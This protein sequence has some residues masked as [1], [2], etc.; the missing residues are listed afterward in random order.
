MADALDQIL[1]DLNGQPSRNLEPRGDYLDQVLA[2][3]DAGYRSGIP[4]PPR[5]DAAG[6]GEPQQ[7]PQEKLPEA[8]G[9]LGATI[10]GAI[11]TAAFGFADEAAGFLETL[12][13]TAGTDATSVWSSGKSFG[14]TLSDNIAYERGLAKANAKE[15]PWAY[16]G[17]QFAGAVLVPFGAGAK[18]ALQVAKVGAVQGAVYGVGSETAP[19]AGA[20]G[21]GDDGVLTRAL[22]GG[23]VGGAAGGLIGKAVDAATPFVRKFLGREATKAAEGLGDEVTDAVGLDVTVTDDTPG[24][25]GVVTDDSP[26]LA[27]PVEVTEAKQPLAW[28]EPDANG[29]RT[30]IFAAEEAAPHPTPEIAAAHAEDVPLVTPEGAPAG[31]ISRA[32]LQDLQAQ[33]EHFRTQ[34]GKSS[35][36][37]VDITASSPEHPTLG[38]FRLG[39]LGDDAEPMSLLGAL[40]RQL[41]GLEP[42][43]DKQ[44]IAQVKA[45]AGELAGGD[46][47]ALDALA[48]QIAGPAGRPDLAIGVLRTVQRR[49]AEEMDLFHGTG[50]DWSTATDEMVQAAGQ[51]IFNVQKVNE[52]VQS[53]KVGAGRALRVFSLPNSERYFEAMAAKESLGAPVAG[54]RSLPPLPSTPEEMRDFFELW[55]MTKRD[56][57]MQ[58][59]LL[60]GTLTVPTSG[61]YLASSFANFFTANILSAPKTVLLNVAGPAVINTVRALERMGGGALGAVNPFATAAERA[62]KA[63]VARQAPLA[64]FRMLGDIRDVWSYGV[65]AFKENHTILGGGGTVQDANISF[66]PYNENLLKAAGAD[67]DW[68]YALGNAINLWPKAFARVNAGLDEMAKRLTYQ[69]EVRVRASVEAATQGLSGEEFKTFVKNAVRSATDEAGAATDEGLLRAAERSTLTAQPGAEGTFARK[70]TDYVQT[71]R[72]DYPLT[73]FIL[74]VFNVPANAVGETLRRIPGLERMPWMVENAADL[75]GDNGVVA[76]A[77]AHGRALLG[78]SFLT[79]GYL[80]N[81]AG[82]LTGGGPQNPQDAKVWR[83]TH[84]PYSLRIGDEWVSYRKLDILG[85]LL[86]IPA[87]LSDLSVYHKADHASWSDVSLTAVG[88]LMTWFKDQAA[89]R[90][91]GQ[92]IALGD[93]PT[94]DPGKT[95]E[96]ITGQMAAGMVPGAGFVRTLGVD[97][98]DPYVRL[99]ESWGDYIR[100]GIPGL[101]Q[102]LEPM[103]NVLGEP[104]NRPNNSLGEAVFPVTMA[105]VATYKA[106]PVLD[107]L[108]RLYRMTGYSAGADPRSL[109]YGFADAQD[110]KLEDGVSLYSHALQAR[111]T[112]KLDG[113]TLKEA[114]TE[115]FNSQEY[116]DAVDADSGQ[117]ITS[118]G[119]MSRGYMTKAVFERYNKAIKAEVAS[120]SPTALKYLTASAAKFRDDAYLNAVPLEDLVKN[121]DLYQAN[122]IDPTAYSDKITEGAAGDLLEALTGGGL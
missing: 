112:M 104:V 35:G 96:R 84:E 19:I 26:N 110:V 120:S 28:T 33:V 100:A 75:A 48:K 122:G 50:I 87:T 69:S 1:S 91:A 46:H 90:T 98:E 53:A 45:A 8:Q 119:D 5:Q 93:N 94:E 79:A 34:V 58:G 14:D 21:V 3:V 39:N 99:K 51:A 86:S 37:A 18:G 16:H 106:E 42:L 70:F 40:T 38:A 32:G 7:Q 66:G 13:V 52:L 81:Q 82:V 47:E 92:L 108:T 6:A 10:A 72:H 80:L 64:L 97:T 83:Q 71:L 17:G 2:R 114:L 88:S 54:E 101:S 60:Q 73:R 23:L 103:R 67:P 105:P 24:L 15:S 121:P 43:D 65:Q 41:E 102:E 109:L 22:E 30:P 20:L 77:E 25:T 63:E 115:L 49:A 31:S 118:Q 95:L 78:A 61:K 55:G 89:M 56:P 59:A 62:A 57:E 11:D 27:H 44:F 4:T 29:T 85:G 116:N 107:E 9:G 113:Q 76:Q 68:K 36:R 111:A 74:P 117:S 12:G